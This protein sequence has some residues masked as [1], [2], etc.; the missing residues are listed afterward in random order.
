MVLAPSETLSAPCR[1][2][3]DREKNGD[4]D[5]AANGTKIRIVHPPELTAALA[6]SER[7][8]RCSDHSLD[9]TGSEDNRV[10]WRAVG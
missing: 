4:G 5:R 7:I 1:R 9:E 3:G 8:R 10:T 6:A 2:H